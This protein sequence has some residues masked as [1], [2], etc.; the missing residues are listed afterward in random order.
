MAD[1]DFKTCP[2]T[3]AK[4]FLLRFQNFP[5]YDFKSLFMIPN[6]SFSRF[7]NFHSTI[8]KLFFFTNPKPFLFAISNVPF[9]DS[10][11]FLLTI[12][13]LS[14]PRFRTLSS[15]NCKVC[16]PTISKLAFPRFR[17]FYFSRFQNFSFCDS[18]TLLFTLPEVPES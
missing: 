14:F 4:P 7:Q 15:H 5:V 10:N 3:I 12:P 9:H 8:S 18:G 1:H 2:L 6:L 13:K 11:T 16:F 17:N